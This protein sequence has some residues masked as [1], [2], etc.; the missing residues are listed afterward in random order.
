MRAILFEVYP[1][2]MLAAEA[3]SQGRQAR[4]QNNLSLARAYYAEA[5]KAYCGQNDSLAYAHTIRHIADM[6]LD[7]LNF[8]EAKPLYEESLE[9]YRGNL[10][11]KLLDLANAVRPYALLNEKLGNT[12][13]AKD[14]WQEARNLYSS[15]RLKEGIRECD[16]H[17]AQ[18]L[19]SATPSPSVI[20]R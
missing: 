11:T 6:H 19:Q 2:A 13:A 16:A 4:T 7:E 1:T 10:S 12:G 3:I 20:P 9:I 14:L 18:L 17:L 15:L 5:A 8:V